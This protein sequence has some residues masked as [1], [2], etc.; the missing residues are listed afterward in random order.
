MLFTEPAFLF[1]FLPVTLLCYYAAPRAGRNGVLLFASL[2][3]Y[4]W[5]ESR[6]LPW[7]VGSIIANYYFALAIERNPGTWKARLYLTLGICVDMAL[8]VVF[9]YAGFIMANVNAMLVH[10]IHLKQIALPLGISFFTFHKI[11]YKVDVYRGVAEAKRSPWQLALY[12]LLFP[13]LIAG[14]IVRYHEIASEL[15]IRQETLSK[16]VYGVERFIGGL[17]KKVLI[18][19]N[20]ALAADRIF[21]LPP[22]DMTASV[23]WLGAF[24]YT[25][26]LYFDFSGY[27]DMAVGLAGMFGFDFPENFNYPYIASSITEF[28]HRWHMTLS[29]WFRDYLYIPLGGNRGTPWTVYRNLVLVFF[30]CGLWHGAAW[31]FVVWGLYHGFFLVAERVGLGKALKRLPAPLQHFYT[32]LVVIVGWV[33]FR[34]D[35]LSHAMAFLGTMFGY[36]PATVTFAHPGVFLDR[37]VVTA[38]AAG[39]VFS[40]PMP[41]S[42]NFFRRDSLSGPGVSVLRL[43][44]LSGVL[45]VSVLLIAAG[46]YSPFIYFRF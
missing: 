16:F 36:A 15:G 44:S 14:P 32:L 1:L 17:G 7:M 46:A 9:K 37:L 2:F 40:I 33:L 38:M 6:F 3:Y 12:I 26:Q 11:S 22:H 29:R 35:S 23:A 18:A 39:V 43:A 28:W 41:A 34:A 19:N 20:V 31:N 45:A 8:L 10:P 42:L 24:C 27:S 4:T 25:L 30:L 5:G 13:Q 21:A